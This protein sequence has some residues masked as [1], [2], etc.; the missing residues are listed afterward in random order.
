MKE[1]HSFDFPS[2][3][4]FLLEQHDEVE[5]YHPLQEVDDIEKIGNFQGSFDLFDEL[6]VFLGKEE[7][8]FHAK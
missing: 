2:F 5:K 1:V 8:K 4:D 3:N 6:L 7:D